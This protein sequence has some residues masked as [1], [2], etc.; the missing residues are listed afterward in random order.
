MGHLVIVQTIAT[1]RLVVGIEYHTIGTG[2]Y[3]EAIVGK[4]AGWREVEDEEQV[5]SHIS[6]YL[7]AIIVPDFNNWCLVKVLFTLNCLEHLLVEVAEIVIAEILVIYQIPLSASILVAPS[8]TLAREINPLWMTELITHEVQVAAIDGRS[9]SQTDHLVQGNASVNHIV[10]ITLLEVPV[11][12]SIY[13]AEDDGLVAYQ[14]LVM[15]LAVRD[16]L[17]VGTAVLDFPRRCWMASSLHPSI[18]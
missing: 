15:T 8:V 9:C 2:R 1:K 17:L 11:H 13:Q 5:A 10:L 14:C 16:G 18:P 3:Q 7:I 12:I 6:E 4:R